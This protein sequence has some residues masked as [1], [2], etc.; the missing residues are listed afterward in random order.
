[1]RQYTEASKKGMPRIRTATD[2]HDADLVNQSEEVKA[3]G[4]RKAYDL[5][6]PI[7]KRLSTKAKGD[8]EC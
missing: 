7:K 6:E 3:R 2:I 5:G 1:M 4:R 8:S